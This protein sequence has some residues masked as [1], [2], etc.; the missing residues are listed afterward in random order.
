MAAITESFRKVVDFVMDGFRGE[1]P[2]VDMNDSDDYEDDYEYVEEGSALREIAPSFSPVV[3]K[4]SE[5]KVLSHPSANRGGNEV[6]VVEPRSFD[7]AATIVQHLKDRKIVMLNLHLLD[8]EQSQRT[9]DFVCG[10]SQALNGSPKKVGDLVFVFAPSNVTL[11]AD[12]NP[13]Q[14]KFNDSLWRT[15]LQ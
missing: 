2:F 11:S 4:Q 14:S 15:S 9:I 10:A 12:T 13:Q 1:N 8:K 5:A 3:E 6:V 7:D